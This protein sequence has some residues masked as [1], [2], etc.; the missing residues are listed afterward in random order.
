MSGKRSPEELKI[1]A[2]KQV[3]DRGY[4]VSDVPVDWA[5]LQKA[6][7]TGSPGT[8]TKAPNTRQSRLSRMRSDS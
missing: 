4:K 1:E 3:T 8:A 7:T 5:S 2:V 6:C